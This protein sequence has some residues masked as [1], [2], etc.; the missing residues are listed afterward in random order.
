MSAY[1]FLIHDNGEPH[2]KVQAEGGRGALAMSPHPEGTQIQGGRGSCH[3]PSSSGD[4]DAGQ[5]THCPN[6]TNRD[7]TM[8]L[9][10]N[11]VLTEAPCHRVWAISENP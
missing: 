8:K 5:L 2:H 11:W 7:V 4:P 1:C 6:V 9:R 10:K 3:V